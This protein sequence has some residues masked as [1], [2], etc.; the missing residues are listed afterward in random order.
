MAPCGHVTLTPNRPVFFFLTPYYDS[1]FS[2]LSA[3]LG[4]LFQKLKLTPEVYL[5]M[6][7]F[8]GIIFLLLLF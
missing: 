1:L 7:L 4:E 2:R 3:A 5:E 6:I 8:R